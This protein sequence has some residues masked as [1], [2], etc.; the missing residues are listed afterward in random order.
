MG[1]E[2]LVES[3]TLTKVTSGRE[4]AGSSADVGWEG[5]AV[6]QAL[7][8]LEV[9]FARF[10]SSI[11][12]INVFPVADGDTGTNMLATLRSAV[13]SAASTTAGGE[14]GS[15]AMSSQLLLNAAARGAVDG[16]RGNSGAI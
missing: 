8:Y 2:A 14:T 12:R 3:G 7:T 16:A 4:S 15:P 13:A 5:A 1:Q 9:E 11:D 6:V 10:A